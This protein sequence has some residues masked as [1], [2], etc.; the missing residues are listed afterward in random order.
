MQDQPDRPQICLATPPA[1]ELMGLAESLA[2]CLDAVP[3][4]CV[5]LAMAGRDADAIG[6]AA[7]HL[8][9]VTHERDVPLVIDTHWMLVE[10]HGLDGVHLLD[11][12]RSVKA[13]RKALGADAIVGADCATSRHDGMTAA[14]LGADYVQFGPVSAGA[15]GDGRLAE[16]E[17]FAWW[18]QM[19]EV[20][21]IASG[22]LDLDSARALAPVT[23]FIELGPEIWEGPDPVA[24]LRGF[25]AAL[26]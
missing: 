1:F 7:D 18:S 2:A 20:P 15:L 16:H 26:G 22:G 13:A 25:D 23:D 9:A 14:E 10:R 5:R 11:G 6:R 3:V 4:A 19:I 12:A 24:L 21:C 17:L 8:R